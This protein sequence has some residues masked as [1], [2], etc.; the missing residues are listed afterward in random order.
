MKIEMVPDF[1]FNI[2]N[3]YFSTAYRKLVHASCCKL[4]TEAIISWKANHQ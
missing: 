4:S 2:I 1:S 3:E